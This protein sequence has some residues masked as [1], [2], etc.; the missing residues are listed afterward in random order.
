MYRRGDNYVICQRSGEKI[1]RSDSVID[2]DNGMI[3]KRGLE[4]P[5]H[6]LEIRMTPSKPRVPSR[7]SP[8]PDDNFLTAN[9]ITAS[10]L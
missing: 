3:V 1:H 9:E 6:P 8:E 7:I 10:D 4:D 5:K 2:G